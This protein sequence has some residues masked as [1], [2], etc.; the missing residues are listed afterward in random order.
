MQCHLASFSFFHSRQTSNI[1]ACE[2]YERKNVLF[3][4]RERTEKK[5]RKYIK[6]DKFSIVF[7]SLFG[8]SSI[9]AVN[10][11]Q[12]TCEKN[13]KSIL[14]EIFL[15]KILKMHNAEKY[16]WK[17]KVRHMNTNKIKLSCNL[18][19]CSQ[20]SNISQTQTHL[21]AQSMACMH[22]YT[23]Y[24]HIFEPIE[25]YIRY[26]LSSILNLWQ[27][28]RKHVLKQFV[29]VCECASVFVRFFLTIC[30]LL[31]LMPNPNDFSIQHLLLH[32]FCCHF[33]FVSFHFVSCVVCVCV[34]VEILFLSIFSI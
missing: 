11:I 31:F 5:T 28:S 3:L 10:S 24:T 14:I 8:V 13:A 33:C 22:A 9:Q 25:I 16:V 20:N 18:S 32:T 15:L 29:C 4:F 1:R 27:K 23:Q 6:L 30:K 34:S 2:C 19:H 26:K 21:Q 12:R 17:S 7:S